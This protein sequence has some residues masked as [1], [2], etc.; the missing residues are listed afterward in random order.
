MK[1]LNTI[2]I[3][4]IAGLLLIS[5]DSQ[6]K[7]ASESEVVL[8]ERVN[9]NTS[10]NANRVLALY[11]YGQAIIQSMDCS[12]P[13]SWFYQGSMH[14]VPPKDSIPG[15]DQLCPAYNSGNPFRAWNSCPHM[16][17]TEKQLNFLTWHRLYTY[18][19]ERNIRYYIANG[20]GGYEGLG[21]EIANEFSLP[22]WDY[23]NQGQMPNFFTI[24]SFSE[25][26]ISL[27]DNPLY[28]EG[29]SPTLMMGQPIDYDANDSIAINIE[30]TVRNLCVQTMGQSLNYDKF[31]A[32]YDVSEFSRGLEDRLHNVMH[33]YIGGAVD[34]IDKNTEIYNRIYQKTAKGFGLMGYIPSAGFDPIFFLH[35]A[36]VDRMMA[37]WEAIY[38]PITIEEM[39]QYAGSWDENG[40]IYQYWDAATNSWVTYENM[41]EMLDA[42][43][44]INYTY[45]ELP[46]HLGSPV[47]QAKRATEKSLVVE[48]SIESTTLLGAS[49]EPQTL[50]LPEAGIRKDGDTKYK[51]EIDISF[52]KDMLEQLL[53][54][55]V[56]EDMD[57]T[58][59]DL[60]SDY[61]H[62]IAAVFG[63]THQHGQKMGDMKHRHTLLVD[64]T[65]AVKNAT[66]SSVDFYIVPLNS[67]NGGD[68]Y[69]EG[70]RLYEV[71]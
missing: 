12:E 43:H 62:G 44:S 65:S 53:V 24:N 18:Y 32:L 14:S 9:A 59:C 34:E 28:E 3:T 69:L 52:D 16:Y 42:A 36:N 66:K 67:E 22:Y 10:A 33:D 60:N 51:L 49:A 54:I 5:C 58:A 11:A 57:W 45:E 21:N 55:S 29:R 70:M 37:T 20:G 8:Y 48:Q 30:G 1:Y 2:S 23:T 41:Q 27:T 64:V 40:K 47:N 6:K 15:G 50:T 46:T 25:G 17:P 39:N 35:H 71:K 56:P 68:F 26:D 31:L 38:G 19:Y 4:F 13:A 7:T 61:I 63:S